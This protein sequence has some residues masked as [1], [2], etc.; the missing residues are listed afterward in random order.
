MKI[1]EI[2][3]IDKKQ[4]TA[5]RKKILFCDFM[6]S[7]LFLFFALMAD[8]LPA[9]TSADPPTVTVRHDDS[10]VSVPLKRTV[11]LDII[12]PPG[13]DFTK[14]D[15]TYPILYLND[16]QD[17]GRLRMTAVLDSLY[18][19]KAIRPFVLVAIHAGDRIQEYGTAA[20]AD[21]T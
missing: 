10:L 8:Y 18:E 11:H 1:E 12:L 6:S 15:A 19:K 9:L 5:S 14:S 17:L 21:Y 13:Y 4:P 20:Q 3:G 16:G 2:A 7:L